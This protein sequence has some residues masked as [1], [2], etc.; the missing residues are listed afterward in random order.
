MTSFISF[1]Q[2]RNND[3]TVDSIC[4]RCYQMIA[5]GHDDRTLTGAETSHL[6]DPKAELDRQESLSRVHPWNG[7]TL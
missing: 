7:G 1:A 3:S 5:S 4:T 6:C 2:R